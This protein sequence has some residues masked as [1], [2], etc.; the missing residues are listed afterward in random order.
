MWIAAILESIAPAIT[1][2][3]GIYAGIAVMDYMSKKNKK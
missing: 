2:V 3:V 1:T